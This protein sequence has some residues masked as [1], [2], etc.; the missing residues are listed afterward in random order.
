M[1]MPGA[2][3]FVKSRNKILTTKKLENSAWTEVVVSLAD[4]STE[5]IPL[6]LGVVRMVQSRYLKFCL[7][8]GAL[9][10]A[11]E[12]EINLKQ[13]RSEYEFE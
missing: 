3:I 12:L 10:S 13:M 8:P 2:C 7:S 5:K 6:A 4:Y 9:G 1:G 11:C